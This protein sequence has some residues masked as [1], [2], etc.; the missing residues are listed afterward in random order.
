MVL[1]WFLGLFPA[2]GAL[3][4]RPEFCVWSKKDQNDLIFGAL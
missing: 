3:T 4:L 1:L 2:C